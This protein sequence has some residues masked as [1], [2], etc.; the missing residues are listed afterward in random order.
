MTRQDAERLLRDYADA[1][2]DV[3][4]SK[5]DSAICRAAEHRLT[6]ARETIIAAMTKET[7]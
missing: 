6:E 7:A 4:T 5:P 2:R 1:V 3:R